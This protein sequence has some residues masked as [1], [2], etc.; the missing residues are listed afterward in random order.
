MMPSSIDITKD[1]AWVIVASEFIYHHQNF[2]AIA[3][4][5]CDAYLAEHPADDETPVD[6]EWLEKVA[7]HG[8]ATDAMGNSELWI[9][10][11]RWHDFTTG[12][13]MLIDH[14]PRCPGGWCL[15]TRGDVRRLARALKID[16]K[17]GQ[18]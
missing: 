17:E 18:L 9:G 14:G 8:W 16:L 7:P 3:A 11:A 5:V 12:G 6:V 4:G 10:P 1:A 13:A 2:A 15:R